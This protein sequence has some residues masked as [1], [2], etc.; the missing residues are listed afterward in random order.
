MRS[1]DKTWISTNTW[2]RIDEWKTIK[3]KIL[4]TKSKIIQE[5]LQLEYS[6]KVKKIKKALGMTR[7]LMWTMLQ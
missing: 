5:R 1:T 6:I 2:R 4:N 7:E 3:S